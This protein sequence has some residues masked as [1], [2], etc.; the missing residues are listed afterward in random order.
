MGSPDLLEELG[1]CSCCGEVKTLSRVDKKRV[2]LREKLQKIEEEK[3]IEAQKQKS[4]KK[5][6]AQK[7][8]KKAG[9]R[10]LKE[11]DKIVQMFE[12]LLEEHS[13][14]AQSRPKICLSEEV[15]EALVLKITFQSE[16]SSQ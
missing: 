14:L 10:R 9:S 16:Q 6:S 15:K 4:A 7:K 2:R 11:N 12:D 13:K 8:R 1:I 5:K 3:K